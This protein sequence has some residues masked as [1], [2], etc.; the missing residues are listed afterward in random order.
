MNQIARLSSPLQRTTGDGQIEAKLAGSDTRLA[1]LFQEGAAKIRLPRNSGG[2][3]EAVLINTAGGLTGGDHLM[4]RASAGAGSHLT[5]TT[6]ACEKLYRS[7]GGEA[8]INIRMDV[9]PGAHIAWLP[10]ET[11]V[12]DGSRTRRRLDAEIA[13]D[14][15]LLVVEAIVFGRTAKGEVVKRALFRDRWRIYQ[16]GRLVHGEDMLLDGDIDALLARPAV[17]GGLHTVATV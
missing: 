8:E 2:G 9:A 5:V 14:A 3:L 16:A 11:I 6:Q 15:S 13:D 4:W 12:Y 7:S 17:A 1:R 10:Q